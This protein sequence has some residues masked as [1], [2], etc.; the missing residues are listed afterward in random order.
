MDNHLRTSQGKVMDSINSQ[1]LIF[2]K[3]RN[4]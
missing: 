1:N 3:I 4:L 2:Q